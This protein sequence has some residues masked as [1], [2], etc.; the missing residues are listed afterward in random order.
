MQFSN[1]GRGVCLAMMGGNDR[2]RGSYN[3][4][5]QIPGGGNAKEHA[6]HNKYAICC[7]SFQFAEHRITSY[8]VTKLQS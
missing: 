6:K 1:P 4:T 8:K 5:L 3:S 2:G 7:F